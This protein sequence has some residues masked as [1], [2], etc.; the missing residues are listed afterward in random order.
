MPRWMV[1][2][3]VSMAVLAVAAALMILTTRPQPADSGNGSGTAPP[4]KGSYPPPAQRTPL[5]PDRI[6]YDWPPLPA[7]KLTDQDGR[8]QTQALLDG[9]VTVIDFIFTN[10]P[11]ACPGMTAEMVAAA[12]SLKGT[13]VRF[14]S[15]SVDPNHDT[16]QRLKEFAAEHGADLSRWTFL[17]G[18]FE[19]VRSIANETLMFELRPDTARPIELKGGGTMDNVV[20]PSKLFLVGPDR[21]LIAMYEYSLPDD[22]QAMVARARGAAAELVKH[23]K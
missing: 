17:T 15:F 7:F 10:C 13:P 8:E 14:V 19:I 23:R 4:D 21:R 9:H 3:A 12:E 6:V 22:M 5:T 1:L 20:H 16:P 2:A 18:P 11:Y